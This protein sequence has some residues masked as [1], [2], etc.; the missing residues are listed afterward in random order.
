MERKSQKKDRGSSNKGSWNK[1]R[2]MKPE[3]TV[4]FERLKVGKRQ[5]Q[6]AGLRQRKPKKGLLLLG[7]QMLL[8]SLLK[9]MPKVHAV[10][11]VRSLFCWLS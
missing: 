7:S 10:V 5:F 4:C 2:R 8:S 11:G 6:T 9:G 3:L 1:T